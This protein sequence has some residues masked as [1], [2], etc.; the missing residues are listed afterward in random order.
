MVVYTSTRTRTI[1]VTHAHLA[2]NR[3]TSSLE[4][5][6]SSAGVELSISGNRGI[7]GKGVLNSGNYERLMNYNFGG[8]EE[9]IVSAKILEL[10]TQYQISNPKFREEYINSEYPGA[11]G[12]YYQFIFDKDVTQ[13][14]ANIV[15]EQLN[16]E[17]PKAY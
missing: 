2:R 14:Q 4:S 16:L 8:V 7:A 12:T 9:D 6:V 15:F 13:Q 11:S 1:P 5:F 3:D 10:C 17:H